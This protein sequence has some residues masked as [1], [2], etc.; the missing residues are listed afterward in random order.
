MGRRAELRLPPGLVPPWVGVIALVFTAGMLAHA[1]HDI[2]MKQAEEAAAEQKRLADRQIEIA[3]QNAAEARR[4][5]D[6]RLNKEAAEAAA[7]ASAVATAS[8]LQPWQ[9]SAA[10]LKCSRESDCLGGTSEPSAILESAKTAIERSTLQAAYDRSQAA[11]ARAQSPLFCCDGE[12]SPSCTCGA[13]H[14]GCC[15]HHGGVCGCSADKK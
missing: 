5:E 14:G 9:R 4:F 6:E 1:C 15:S 10:I 13:P 11:I 3:Q 12:F 7:H 8:R 2:R